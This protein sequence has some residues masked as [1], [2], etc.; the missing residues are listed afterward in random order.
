MR[1]SRAHGIADDLRSQITTG[2]LQAAQR[3]P[4]EAE[5][6]T[7]YGVSTAT[8]R[9]ALGILQAEGL[10]E[11]IHGRGNFVRRPLRRTTYV[12]GWGTLDPRTAADAA[13]RVTIRTTKTADTSEHPAA[14]LARPAGTVLTEILC[15]TYDGEVPH[16]LARTCIPHDTASPPDALGLVADN[17]PHQGPAARFA[18]LTPPPAEVRETVCSRLPTPD[19]ASTLH[20]RPT[21]TVLVITRTTTDA[22]GLTVEAAQLV[23]PADRVNAV[24]TSHLLDNAD[25]RQPRP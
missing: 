19:E 13:Q 8:L 10:V 1:V 9:N 5:L 21:T 17:A 2:Q 7:R 15:I 20:I 25:E 23:F 14:L 16:G 11:K 12:G 22:A 4:S 24:F 18:V 6:A 3:L